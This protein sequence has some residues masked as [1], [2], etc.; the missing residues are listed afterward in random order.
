MI[1]YNDNDKMTSI[2]HKFWNNGIWENDNFETREYDEKGRL[3][4]LLLKFWNSDQWENTHRSDYYYDE[5]NNL[6]TEI[7][8]SWNDGEWEN[9][10]RFTKSFIGDSEVINQIMTE[11][12]DGEEWE[13]KYLATHIYDA[14][15]NLVEADGQMWEN[16]E[17]V[18]VFKVLY[19][20]GSNNEKFMIYQTFNG[21][22]WHNGTRTTMF[23]DENDL[24]AKVYCE[25]W[26][27]DEWQPDDGAVTIQMPYGYTYGHFG[28]NTADFYY[29]SVTD[30][31]TENELPETFSLKQNYPN[32]FS[33]GSD[34]N[35]STTIEYT[36]PFVETQNL[37][38]LQT[39]IKIYDILGN[40][41]TT[42][43]DEEQSP[44]NYSVQFSAEK[45]SAGVY[46]Y[47]LQAGNFA[48]TKKMLLLK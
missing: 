26:E 14:D 29:H 7:S 11:T 17:W 39:T 21:T 1:E 13:R 3:L 33:K 9:T 34:G 5:D 8:Q 20:D 35:S 6:E 19:K 40:E 36:I 37:A 41:I 24:L 2:L 28:V 38:P 22:E 15:G 12:W 30:V 32:P 23:Y 18:D 42:L 46:F 45:L 16:G 31:E 48:Q 4:L 43:I 47:R 10:F 44:G 25:I 27:N